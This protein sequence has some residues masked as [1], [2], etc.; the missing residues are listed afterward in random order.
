LLNNWGCYYKA[1]GEDKPA[2]E[3]FAK[4]L[5]AASKDLEGD[6]LSNRGEALVA[7]GRY[8]E[9]QDTL[10][11]SILLH[12]RRYSKGHEKVVADM[13]QLASCCSHEQKLVY[14][15]SLLHRAIDLC[16]VALD[17]TDLSALVKQKYL[18]LMEQGLIK[19][20][21]MYAKQGRTA[22]SNALQER[23]AK[24]GTTPL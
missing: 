6:I 4:A 9:A 10:E 19:L 2:E 8:E 5:K 13:L 14:A 20:A 18:G 21:A 3:Y 23:A 11:K 12:E 17:R 7:L 15:E 1:K 16:E 24:L 22:E